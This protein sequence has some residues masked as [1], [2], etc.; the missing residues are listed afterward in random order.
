M[1]QAA[2]EEEMPKPN[3]LLNGDADTHF[4]GVRQRLQ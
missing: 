3:P 4:N 2:G 1:M